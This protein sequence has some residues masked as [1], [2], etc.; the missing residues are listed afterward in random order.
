MASRLHRL[1]RYSDV[2]FPRETFVSAQVR[3]VVQD[4][5]NRLKL[6]E[7]EHEHGPGG[8][9]SAPVPQRVLHISGPSG[10]G[11][12]NA[13]YFGLKETLQREGEV[14]HLL[15]VTDKCAADLKN[16]RPPEK[17]LLWVADFSDD[18]PG[19]RLAESVSCLWGLDGR[20]AAG[21]VVSRGPSVRAAVSSARFGEICQ[22]DKLPAPV[23]V[24]FATTAGPPTDL[25]L[26]VSILQRR[27]P[28]WTDPHVDAFARLALLCAGSQVRYLTRLLYSVP[29]A[30]DNEDFAHVQGETL[31]KW[32]QDHRTWEH[33]LR[34]TAFSAMDRED[35]KIA[36]A[37]YH[38]LLREL[39]VANNH[40]LDMLGVGMDMGMGMDMDMDMSMDMDMAIGHP[41]ACFDYEEHEEHEDPSPTTTTPTPPSFHFDFAD[42][43]V[44]TPWFSGVQPIAFPN[45]LSAWEQALK[46]C[47]NPRSSRRD[48]LHVLSLLCDWG[49]VSRGQ[50]GSRV[51][52]CVYPSSVA[53]ILDV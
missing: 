38:R 10:I 12:T 48:M 18:E 46:D 42:R 45:Y 6:N 15:M 40:V 51:P 32:L 44:T 8:A 22:G 25:G 33:Y 34:Q 52:A 47:G 2:K 1:W 39:R 50:C 24:T 30:L 4:H 36:Q 14:C 21:I 49:L 35:V 43:V 41:K 28:A 11:L 19:K 37:F 31:G 23:E 20:K 16:S 26:G 9:K 5:I 7:R 27:M 17:R 29:S 3:A 13:L 53:S